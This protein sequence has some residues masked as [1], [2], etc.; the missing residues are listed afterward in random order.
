[1]FFMSFSVEN[2]RYK[3]MLQL[4]VVENRNEIIVFTHP[5]R[6]AFIDKSFSV[7]AYYP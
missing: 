2:K 4:S 6:D 5:G 3:I 1:M 7:W